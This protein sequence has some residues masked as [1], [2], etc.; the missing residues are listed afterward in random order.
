M[1]LRSYQ[2]EAVDSVFEQWQ[3]YRSTLLVLPTGCGKTVIFSEITKRLYERG[4]RILIIA[5][6]EELLDQA[7]K[8]LLLFSVPS[9]LEKAE[10]H[11]Y[12]QERVVVASVQTLGREKRLSEY[13]EDYFDVIITDEA[14]HSVTSGYKA[15]FDYFKNAKLLGVTATPNR[16]DMRSLTKTYETVAYKYDIIT[17]I[18]SGYLSKI[19][20]RKCPLKIDLSHVRLT[21]GDFAAADLEDTL[22]PY[23]CEISNC[24]KKYARSRKTLIFTPTVAIGEEFAALLNK[25]GFRAAC[26]SSKNTAQEREEI[27]EKLAGGDLNIVCNAM[28]WTEGFDEPS[29][30]CIINLRA[31]K[32]VSL[33][34]QIIGR[35]L[36][37]SPGKENLLI[38]DFLWQTARKSLN[39]LAP[40]D[41]F[42]D[43]EDKPYFKKHV[44]DGQEHDLFT[45]MRKSHE[46]CLA[47]KLKNA[48][49]HFFHGIE[50]KEKKSDR[51]S[52]Y[53]DDNDSL[54]SVIIKDCEA[55]AFLFHKGEYEFTPF[56]DWE[57]EPVS[58]PQMEYLKN[59]IG[60]DASLIQFKGQASQI[61]HAHK[62]RL[63]KN[64]CSFKQYSL[65]KKRGFKNVEKWTHSD[66]E[67]AISFLAKHNWK[68]PRYF[69]AKA[70]IPVSMRKEKAYG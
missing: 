4:K 37:L 46:E 39:I 62:N 55:L 10:N 40:Q 22:E 20:I 63:L 53:Y 56:Y 45:C 11:A 49:K 48:R 16:S 68:V 47:Q 6:R 65:L 19:N 18:E 17:A 1:Q 5:H 25:D 23:L 44:E 51:I 3:Q 30:D 70:Y 29:V 24:I 32:S 8:K 9:S 27:K 54:D 21:C 57:V 64:K 7:A 35:G 41:L 31:T 52:Y 60:K 43:E 67:E 2:N 59:I 61:I 36:R 66:A 13:P 12:G 42:I 34:T 50:I 69:S 33:Y 58:D 26:V 38:L 28:L 15:I 14:H